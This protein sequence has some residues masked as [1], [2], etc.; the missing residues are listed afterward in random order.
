M[1]Q[2][3]RENLVLQKKYHTRA[4]EAFQYCLEKLF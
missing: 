4:F 3:E 1:E 2:F